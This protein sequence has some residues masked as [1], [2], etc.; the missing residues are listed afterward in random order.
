MPGFLQNL[1]AN[2]GPRLVSEVSCLRCF[3][4]RMKGNQFVWGGGHKC[5]HFLPLVLGSLETPVGEHCL[6][7]REAIGK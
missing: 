4:V 1:Q 6:K 5:F 7:I 3:D 2:L